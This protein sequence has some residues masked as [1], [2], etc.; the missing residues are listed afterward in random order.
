MVIL[1]G[2]LYATGT[3]LHRILPVNVNMNRV[4]FIILCLVAFTFMILIFVLIFISINRT[5]TDKGPSDLSMSPGLIIF[6][7][8]FITFCTFYCLY[9]NAKALKA[10]ELQRPVTIGDYAGEF[11]LLL[12]F[13]IGVWI[14]QPRLNKLFSEK[15]APETYT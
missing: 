5:L 15:K 13:M 7:F 11:I 2:W 14:I 8:F 3:N 10:V 12:F 9:F 1:F 6:L 4:S